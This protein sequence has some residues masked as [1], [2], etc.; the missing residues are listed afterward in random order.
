M[1]CHEVSQV[2]IMNGMPELLTGAA[3]NWFRTTVHSKPF[4]SFS[5]FASRF[6]EDFEPFYKVDTRL[7]ML[8][9]RL[10]K[11][12]ERIVT[13]FSYVE[14]EFLTMSFTPPK[15]EQIR[16]VRRLLL[17][18]FITHLACQSFTDLTE[19][20]DAC[21]K[22]ELS[23]EIVKS[24]NGVL[25]LEGCTT[26]KRHGIGN[27]SNQTTHTDNYPLNLV[28]PS[29]P[30]NTYGNRNP[31]TYN[32][33]L[34]GN[35]NQRPRKPTWNQQLVANPTHFV[36]NNPRSSAPNNTYN[37]SY[38]RNPHNL[39]FPKYPIQ[40][41]SLQQPPF[42]QSTYLP[43]N[44]PPQPQQSQPQHRF[45][46]N[47]NPN[48]KNQQHVRF[49]NNNGYPAN[50][51]QQPPP[52]QNSANGQKGYGN[53]RY[54]SGYQNFYQGMNNNTNQNRTQIPP[55]ANSQTSS[56]QV[57]PP[58]VACLTEGETA[59]IPLNLSDQLHESMMNMNFDEMNQSITENS[60]DLTL[61][62]TGDGAEAACADENS[63]N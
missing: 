12:N 14:N 3:A 61:N 27:S 8:K 21:K 1:P 17:P 13:F 38:Q 51:S 4:T 53:N 46:T 15:E 37:Q 44:P 35:R 9:K 50:Y 45:G 18:H 5:D 56:G 49:Q 59:L 60:V 32:Y 29:R 43:V 58:K 36:Q 7:E 20:K 47:Q 40:P 19:L 10:Q 30:E 23:Y 16:I 62:S 33:E 6:L 34:N 48:A 39:Q 55:S 22:I 42:P 25:A 28:N 24:Q 57:N 2:E 63:E 11:P 52:Q 26:T 54:S 31:N 41:D